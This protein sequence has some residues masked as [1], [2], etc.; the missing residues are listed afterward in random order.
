MNITSDNALYKLWKTW[1]RWYNALEINFLAIFTLS[2][3]ALIII[4]III[5]AFGLQGFRWMEELGRFMLVTT[6]LIGCSYAV[7]SNGHM[8]MDALYTILPIRVA[9]AMRALAHLISTILYAYLG[10]YATLWMLKLISIGKMMESIR[11]P[12][13]VM[14]IFVSIALVTMSFRY[15]V[16]FAKSMKKTI[17]GEAELTETERKLQ[18]IPNQKYQGPHNRTKDG[19][20]SNDHKSHKS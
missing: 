7:K 2:T 15:L 12:A 19:V 1:C 4:E 20:V 8:V 3:G 17:V 16:Q 9:N 5:R 14:W 10:W 6:T 13:F 18:E 11:F